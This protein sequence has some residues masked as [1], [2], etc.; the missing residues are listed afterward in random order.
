MS[1]M[2]LFI[3]L[4]L[5]DLSKALHIP[6]FA[7]FKNLFIAWNIWF[8]KANILNANPMP[9]HMAYTTKLSIYDC[10][11][12]DDPSIYMSIIGSFHY[13]TITRP[14]LTFVG[15][16]VFQFMH[17]LKCSHWISF[18]Q[19]LRYLQVNVDYG[20]TLTPSTNLIISTLCDV[21][22]GSHPYDK[23]S[24]QCYCFYVGNNLVSWSSKKQTVVSRSS[25][26]MN[27]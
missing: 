5:S 1:S 26:K 15:N 27:T 20:L 12:F 23:K 18:K 4:N 2:S 7:S 16:K 3:W 17:N 19:I 21:Y 6:H 25:T 11:K 10:L 14:N 24:T 22:W 13:V 8:H 9:T